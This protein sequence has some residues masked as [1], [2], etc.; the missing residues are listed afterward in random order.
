MTKAFEIDMT[1]SAHVAAMLDVLGFKTDAIQFAPEGSNVKTDIP[2]RSIFT[3]HPELIRAAAFHGI[4]GKLGNVSKGGLSKSLDRAA[5]DADLAKAR[6]KIVANWESGDWNSNR[7]GPRD[8]MAGDMREAFIQKQV[9]LGKT[10]KE[11][12]SM[13]RSTVTTAF[14]KDEKATFGKFLEAV[15]TIKAKALPEGSD[16]SYDSILESLTE[17]A[18][19][20]ARKLRAER[21]ESVAELDID[22][23]LF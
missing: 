14:G 18:T 22:A 20:A 13:I 11:A 9:S 7:T 17:A 4:F 1:N 5:T 3:A 10:V 19:E 12:D 23:D 21:A 2:V 15:A 8:S 6:D 16:E